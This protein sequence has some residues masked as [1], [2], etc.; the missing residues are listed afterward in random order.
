MLRP[1]RALRAI[2]LYAGV[3]GWALGLRMAGID[4]VKS[5]E[6]WKP[7]VETNLRN[8]RHQAWTGNLRELKPEDLPSDIDI[9]VGSPPCTQ[10]SFANRGGNGDIDDGLTDVVTFLTIVDRLRPRFWLME[11][12]PRLGRIL[13][14]EL[15]PGGRLWDFRHLGLRHTT[16]NMVDFGVPQRRRRCIAG[17][18]DFAALNAFAG[19]V[20]P[21]TLGD[22]VCA[23]G[24]DLPRDP[25]YGLQLSPELLS[26][27][28]KEIPLSLE[29]VRVNK[30]NKEVHSVYNRM[31]FP[32]SLE[33]SVRT[34][35]ATCTRV[36]RESIII[37]NG[38]QIPSYRRLSI[39]ERATLQTFPITFQFFGASYAQ[40]L[41]LVGNAIPPLFSYFAG[42]AMAG[43]E[44]RLARKPSVAVQAFT[45]PAD[46]APLT[47]LERPGYKYSW[48]RNFRFA[49]PSLRLKSGVRFELTNVFLASHP[50]W[51]VAFVFGTSKSIHSL[52]LG[53]GLLKSISGGFIGSHMLNISEE[54]SSLANYIRES[55]ICNMQRAWSKT[56]PGNTLP[57]TVLDRLDQSGDILGNEFAQ[58]GNL[59]HTIVELAIR[60]EY[61]NA[62]SQLKGITKLDKNASRIAAGMLVG[63]VFNIT[64]TRPAPEHHLVS[65]LHVAL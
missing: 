55:D 63:S 25:T 36:S 12:V 37:G 8:N 56:G 4:V 13:D 27:H 39:R 52:T 11:N 64:I 22:V 20:P 10:F 62:S 19:T 41:K 7:A 28:E 49:I 44:P 61:G 58:L 40:K 42:L 45:P 24:A 54:I 51:E 57:F 43:T 21:T 16:V 17:N 59:A 6:R 1:T 30:A 3:G 33:T 31:A 46:R 47:D 34:I 35:T 32:D 65:E 53:R 9:V 14:E 2:D 48:D 26:D 23:L 15:G 18:I 50:G 5:Y 29:E 38:H 60:R